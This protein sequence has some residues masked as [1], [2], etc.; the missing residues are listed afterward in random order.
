MVALKRGY[1]ILL[2][3]LLLRGLTVE[4][5]LA[6]TYQIP[7]E[8]AEHDCKESLEA[9]AANITEREDVHIDIKKPDLYLNE[10]VTF[11]LLNS[12][13]ISGNPDSKTTINCTESSTNAGITLEKIANLTLKNLTLIS[14]GAHFSLR[15]KTYSSAL[16]LLNCRDVNIEYLVI[17]K[18]K[19]IGLTIHGHKEGRLC[20]AWSNFTN[21][22]LLASEHNKSDVRG[23]GGVYIGE[24]LSDSNLSLIF[25]F[26][27]CRF[28]RNIAHTKY[29]HSYYSDEFGQERTGYGQGGGV[30]LAIENDIIHSSVSVHFMNCMYTK[31]EAFLGGGLST[32]LGRTKIQSDITKVEITIENSKFESNGC[33]DDDNYTRIGG[34]AYLSYNSLRMTTNDGIQYRFHNVEFTE[35]CAELGGGAF[36]LSSRYNSSDN[37]ILFNNCKFENNKAH[38]GSAV[39]LIPSSFVTTSGFTLVPVF[40]NCT[41]LDN[42]V[43]INS[44]HDHKQMT[45][46]IGTFYATLYNIRFEEINCFT[47]NTGTA[48]YLVN[49]IA[50]FS[51]SNAFFCDNQ[52]ERGGAIA[53]IGASVLLVGPDK[54]YRFTNNR[55]LYKGGAL[56]VSLITNH[57]FTVSRSCFIQ[58][59]NG[60]KTTLTKN[61]NTT[62]SFIGNTAQVGG[63]IF[64]TS[65]YPCQTINNQT[66]DSPFFITVDGL[67]AFLHRGI[68]IDNNEV[69]TAGARLYRQPDNV[70]RIIPGRKYEHNVT[71]K[72]DM[73][74]IVN[75]PLREIIANSTDCTEIL[76]PNTPYYVGEK[77]QF[78][79]RP[80]KDINLYLHTV[81]TRDSY[82]KIMV[83]LVECPPGFKLENKE[84][85]CNFAE[86]YG[87]LG[88][89]S[90]HY[91]S[92]LALGLWAGMIEDE[93]VTSVCP[94]RFCDYDNSRTNNRGIVSAITLPHNTSEL[95]RAICGKTRNGVLCGECALGYTTRFHSPDFTCKLA[96]S[97]LCKLGWLFYILSELVPVTVVFI[98]VLVFNI[99]FTSGPVN[100]FILFS[101]ILLSLNIDASGI[102]TFPKQRQIT[103]GYQLLYGFLNLDFFS[104]DTLSFCLWPKATA[105]DMLAFKYITIVYALSLVIL[106]IWFMNRCGGRCFGKWCRITTVKS[107]VIHGISAFLIICYSQSITVSSSLL[108]GVEMWRKVDSNLNL[109]WRVWQNGNLFS[110]RGYHLLYALPAL[111]CWLT[112]GILPPTLLVFYPLYNRVMAFF[113]C[114]ESKLIHVVSR[115]LPISSLK[116]LLDSFQGCF[117]DNLRFFAGLYFVYR[118]TAPLVNAM[119]SSLGTAYIISEGLLIIML[120]LHALFQPYQ[121]R[122][123]NVIDTL[124][125]TDLLLINSITFFQYYLF[126]SQESRHAIKENISKA[127]GIQM[128]L[129]YLPIFIIILYM[130]GVGCKYVYCLYSK[131]HG[132]QSG[133]EADL[134]ETQ[135][136]RRLRAAVR[137]IS[138]LSGDISANDEELPHRFIAGEVSYECFEDTDYARE[139]PTDNKSM[140]DIVTY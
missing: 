18:S 104:I 47:N 85:V 28:E 60:N 82:I 40:R 58:F 12:L 111:F 71:I 76:N 56:Y 27:H 31:N 129:I 44:D 89:D 113:G 24:F 83:K 14:C 74:N 15:N 127:A 100:G 65:L 124:L 134:P 90:D 10:N 112:I 135:T 55:A 128:T 93:L 69:A 106:V 86:Y 63:D 77:V 46:G 107:S 33:S 122:V 72:D 19:G 23:G 119:T 16:R 35:N 61:W 84:C 45:A 1:I 75:E 132:S 126:Q 11:N 39:D 79:D 37:K 102:I 140:Q 109:S 9:I 49:S 67:D 53:L 52:G 80:E 105:L 17:T 118:W 137:S 121:K 99:S 48:L 5:G 108:N 116:P 34:G 36:I 110:F 94:R 101:Q 130:L 117:K 136:L 2:V 96:D 26:E 103:E 38:T 125:F 59:F 87:L 138:S 3:I 115:K 6:L 66:E 68:N 70:L 81:S 32:K 13:I 120:A 139:M 123:H 73:N 8:S 25:E 98:T 51:Q 21:N 30:F 64:T 41:F 43:F 57:Y 131:N 78:V 22:R 88:C 92:L 95:N 42:V 97:T 50:N 7:C 54:E 29:F 114:E 4:P 62:I 20:V 133:E 91:Q